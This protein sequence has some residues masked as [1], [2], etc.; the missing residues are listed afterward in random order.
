VNFTEDATG[1]KAGVPAP[2]EHSRSILD[3]LRY[4]E[5]AIQTLVGDGV[6]GISTPDGA[7]GS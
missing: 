4:S 2:G 6:V 3:E 7:D 5:S 1:V